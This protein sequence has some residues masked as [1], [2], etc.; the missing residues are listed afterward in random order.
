M[1]SA[2]DA[3]TPQFNPFAGSNSRPVC[4]HTVRRQIPI[5]DLFSGPG[6]LAEGFSA[7]TDAGGRRRF[8]V[9]LS[10]ETD[11]AA[12]RTLRLRAFLRKFQ[13]AFPDEYYDYLNGVVSDEPQ[14]VKLYPQKWRNACYETRCLALST[15]EAASFVRKRVREIRKLHGK[16]SVLLGGPPCQSYSVVGRSRNVG[17][18]EYDADQDERQFLYREYVSVLQQLQPAVAVMEN[19][20][21][22]LSALQNGKPIF[23]DVMESLRHAGGKNR[24]RLFALNADTGGQSWGE[25]LKA[26]DFLVRAEAH[27]IPQK[28]HRVFVICIRQDVAKGLPEEYLPKLEPLETQ[29]ILKEVLGNMPLLRSRLSGADDGNSWQIAIRDAYRLVQ[30]HLPTMAQ[31]QERRFRRALN[32]A[33]QSTRGSFLPYLDEASE[34]EIAR[35]CPETLKNWI[36][37]ENLTRFPNHETRRHMREDIARYLFA[38]AFAFAFDRSPKAIDFPRILAPKH[39]S[40]NTGNFNDRFRVQLCDGPSTTITSHI[41]KDGHYFIHPDTRQC[42]SLTVREAARLQT[43]PDNYFFHGHR[44]QQYVQVGNAVPPYLAHQIAI[45][46]RKV[47]EF[48]DRMAARGLRR[49]LSHRV[50]NGARIP[51]TKQGNLALTDNR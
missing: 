7:I 35:S 51:R 29:V 22:M 31:N 50:S 9:A 15:V 21:G 42:R 1:C 46:V 44:T 11:A 3:Q 33:L 38:G 45:Q 48:R 23:P 26:E 18:P 20:R 34:T 8:G 32:R 40:W 43:F 5:V 16:R 10:I 28:R 41:A 17:N 27:G 47:L 6:G 4:A 37:D 14:W 2:H 13:T 19:V 24:Y 49:R 39:A 25:G 30:G 36:F 12:H